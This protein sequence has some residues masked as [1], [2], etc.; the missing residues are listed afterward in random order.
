MGAIMPLAKQKY[1]SFT[2]NTELKP[3]EAY[4][5]ERSKYMRTEILR[6]LANQ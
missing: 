2:P 5:R 1:F 6:A 4:L 3:Q